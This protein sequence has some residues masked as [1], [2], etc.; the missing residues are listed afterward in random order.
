MR[1]AVVLVVVLGLAA[2]IGLLRAHVSPSSA[3]APAPVSLASP[4]PAP[5]PGV[6]LM[7]PGTNGNPAHYVPAKVTIHAGDTLTWVDMDTAAHSATS[8]DGKFD[9]GVLSHG[10]KKSLTFKTPGTYPY[11]DIIDADMSGVIRVT[12]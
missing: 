3:A 11:S 6:I 12:S 10:Q 9:T 7:E 8:N 1:N 4:T 2:G 5:P